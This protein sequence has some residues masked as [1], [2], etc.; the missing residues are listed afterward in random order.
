VA[1]ALEPGAATLDYVA[2]GD[3]LAEG[4]LSAA[5]LGVDEENNVYVGG[6]DL[7]GSS[8]HLGYAGLISGDVVTRVLAGGAPADPNRND[9]LTIIAP[10]PCRNDDFTNVLFVPGVNMLSVS[11]NAN[12]LPPDCAPF[13]YSGG[14]PQIGQLY[15][16]DDAPDTD[17]DGVPDGADNAYLV[18][19]PAQSDSD[20]DGFGDVSDCDIDND[21][22]FGRAEL[23]RLVDAFGRTATGSTEFPAELDFNHDDAIDFADFGNLKSRW[24]QAA[25]CE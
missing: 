8:A 7:F 9:D 12:S 13:D 11:Y 22:F 21:G 6:G 23:S 14:G 17:S 2:T 19:N 10:D 3:I 18:A 1:A 5:S 25:I 15:F 20:G 16:P 24:G 4:M